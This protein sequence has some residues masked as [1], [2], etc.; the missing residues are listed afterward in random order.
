[1]VWSTAFSQAFVSSEYG[2]K[3][4]QNMIKEA[5]IWRKQELTEDWGVTLSSTECYIHSVKF[6]SSHQSILAAVFLPIK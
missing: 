3:Y 5:Y 4:P 6:P 2:V 1:M